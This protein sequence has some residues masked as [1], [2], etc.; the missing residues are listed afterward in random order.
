M[1]NN[2]KIKKSEYNVKQYLRDDL[3]R[4]ASFKKIIF[5]TYMKNHKESLLLAKKIYNENLSPLWIIVISYYSMFYIAN[6]VLY[7]LGYKIGSKIAHKITSDS[8]IVFV[9]HKLKQELIENYE[10]ATKEALTISNNLIEN[11]EYERR[12]RSIFQYETTEEIKKAKAKTSLKRA[13]EFNKEMEK[14]LMNL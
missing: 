13:E 2:E 9:R 5:D 10:I 1:L 3:I 7:K 4:K 8:L 14:L 12:K 11:F 6:A